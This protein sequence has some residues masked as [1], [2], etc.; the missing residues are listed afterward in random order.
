[1]VL[2]LPVM[3][4][5]TSSIPEFPDSREILLEDKPLL[6]RLL[7]L[8]KPEISAY[9][10]TNMFAWRNDPKIEISRIGDWIIVHYNR[11]D[12]RICLEPLGEGCFKAAMEVALNRAGAAPVEL[13][14]VPRL[15]AMLFED[16]KDLSV[17]LD[18]DNCDY[19]YLAEDLIALAGRKFDA[20]RNFISRF[21]ANYDYEYV[22]M[23]QA[24]ALECHEFAEQ[25]C[26]DRSCQTVEGLR[27]ERCAVYQMLTHFDALG[28]RG[29]AIRVDGKIV[30]FSLGELLNPET[31]VVHVE[32]A[33]SQYRGLYQLINNEF[34]IQE[35]QNVKYVNREQDMGIEGLRKAKESYQPVRLVETYRVRKA[36]SG[37]EA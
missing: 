18:R 27:R 20:K 10:F 11:S 3:E 32:K 17:E 31:L 24:T 21:K 28:I 4:Q 23:T 26:E 29:G 9:T 34:C 19:L 16:R 22:P 36:P 12:S 35:A 7:A 1:M 30:A 37:A 13:G 2:S 15:A 33:D 5:Q 8:K 6:D 25:W 14:Y